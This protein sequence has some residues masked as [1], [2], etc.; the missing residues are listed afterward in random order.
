M[1]A[2]A[3]DEK[4]ITHPL[5]GLLAGRRSRRLPPAIDRQISPVHQSLLTPWARSVLRHVARQYSGQPEIVRIQECNQGARG[6][7]YSGVT[8]GCHATIARMSY[9]ANS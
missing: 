6:L 8:C 3:V 4:V 1:Q 9:H 2:P 5:K 7:L